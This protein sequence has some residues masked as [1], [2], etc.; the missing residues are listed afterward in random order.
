MR[1]KT[2]FVGCTMIAAVAIAAANSHRLG[3]D[4]LWLASAPPPPAA[5]AVAPAEP[6][7]RERIEQ[8]LRKVRAEMAALRDQ[9]RDYRDR[10]AWAQNAVRILKSEQAKD[11]SPQVVAAAEDYRKFKA[12]AVRAGRDLEERQAIVTK[13]QGVWE[14]LNPLPAGGAPESSAVEEANKVLSI[15][16][17]TRNRPDPV[18]RD[19]EW[20]PVR[21]DP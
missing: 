4:R 19:E 12:T 15:Y 10:A 1:T 6:S 2:L 13:L 9:A 21:E 11:D 20:Q 16:N 5:P 8:A 3:L 17:L 18:I 7:L 14:K